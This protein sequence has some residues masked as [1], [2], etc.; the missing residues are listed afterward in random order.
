[1]PRRLV[2]ALTA[3]A[4]GAGAAAS[5]AHAS[6]PAAEAGPAVVRGPG[7]DSCPALSELPEGAEPADW[8][9]EAMTADGHLTLGRMDQALGR[10]MT[11]TFAEGT[12]NGE[13]HQ[14]FG[15]MTAAPV[16]VGG[17][18]LKLTPR[19]AGHFDFHENDERRGELDLAFRLSGPAVPPS[20]SIGT[21]ADPVRLKLKETAAPTV[22]SKEP[23]VVAFSVADNAFS[24]PRTSGCGR[25]GP[26]IDAALRLPSPTGAN[27]FDLDARVAFR[28]Y[29]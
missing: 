1:M 25:L 18:F 22:V 28:S 15:R 13:F 16:R 5:P 26:A 24:A 7:F 23:L 20:C 6:V 9:C 14:V 17:T 21:D 8:R 10:G 3:L 11:I 4:L 19:Y 2:L 12:V 27:A 29:S